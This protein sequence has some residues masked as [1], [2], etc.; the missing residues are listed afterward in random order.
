MFADHDEI[1]DVA[2]QMTR[3]KVELERSVL[4]LRSW[5]RDLGR[6]LT[7]SSLTVDRHEDLRA[8]GETVGGLAHNLNNSLAAILAYAE[9]MLRE[10]QTDTARRRLGVMRDVALEASTTVR[11]LQ[12]FVSRQPQRAFG[13]VGLARGDRRGRGD[14]RAALAGRGAT[15]RHRDHHHTGPGGAASG[16]GR[17][18]RVAGRHCRAHPQRGGRHATGRRADDS[19]GQRGARRGDRRGA[20]H[21]RGDGRAGSPDRDGPRPYCEVGPGLRSRS[22]SRL[23]HRGASRRDAR[24]RERSRQGNDR[25]DP[26]ARQPIPDHPAFARTG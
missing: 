10:Q 7:H 19:G 2:R 5:A 21:R 14:D 11:R 16:R 22:R 9:M 4:T 1:Q 24:H 3:T 25:E 12:E 17:C 18:V 23:R 8:L 6:R 13:P 26:A 20:G 15:P